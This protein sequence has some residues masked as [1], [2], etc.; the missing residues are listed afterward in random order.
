MN[1]VVRWTFVALLGCGSESATSNAPDATSTGS[2]STTTESPTTTAPV[3]ATMISTDTGASS[4]EEESSGSSGDATGGYMS[5]CE[6]ECDREVECML[7]TTEDCL[8]ACNE[9]SGL[10]PECD[11]AATE[12]LTCEAMMTCE[13]LISFVDDGDPGPCA[14]QFAAVARACPEC[15]GSSGG[16]ATECQADR[17]C[18]GEPVVAVECDT[19]TCT[20][21]EDG[22]PVGTC[23]AMGVCMAMDEVQPDTNWPEFMAQ[24]CGF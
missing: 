9:G 20:C 1:H 24:C 12:F 17:S 19:Q 15:G 8:D 2:T 13:E 23:P 18:A 10:G 22:A 14:D 6:A 11:A 3:E 16:N 4:H 21:F 7:L 5:A